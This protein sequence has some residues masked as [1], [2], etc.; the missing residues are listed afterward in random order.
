MRGEGFSLRWPVTGST[1]RRAVR[2]RVEPQ[3]TSATRAF[4]A[5]R[6]ALELTRVIGV[7]LELARGGMLLL[8]LLGDGL[9]FRGGHG[10]LVLSGLWLSGLDRALGVAH[11]LL[12]LGVQH[13]A[14]LM[15]G[16]Q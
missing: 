13:V 9:C 14:G 7:R 1:G 6:P 3:I 5:D 2:T 4:I 11:L 16:P 15:R 12:L 8:L 10:H